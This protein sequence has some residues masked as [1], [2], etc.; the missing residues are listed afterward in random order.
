[1]VTTAYL[2]LFLATDR[3]LVAID[4][5]CQYSQLLADRDIEHSRIS[6]PSTASFLVRLLFLSLLSDVGL[7]PAPDTLSRSHVTKRCAH[8]ISSNGT[9]LAPDSSIL[10]VRIFTVFVSCKTKRKKRKVRSVYAGY[11]RILHR[12]RPS[13][14]KY[15]VAHRVFKCHMVTNRLSIHICSGFD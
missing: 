7:I 12:R 9:I 14:S 8:G 13:K 5:T 2:A 15:S 3:P 11:H 10:Q 4:L 6:T 1:L